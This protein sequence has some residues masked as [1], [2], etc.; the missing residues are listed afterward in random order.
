MNN[1]VMTKAE[2]DA[3]Y[4]SPTW[5]KFRKQYITAH[6]DERECVLCLHPV[7]G[8]NLILDH[9]V[10]IRQGGAKTDENNIQVLCL[11]CNSRKRSN[12]YVRANFVDEEMVKL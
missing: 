5:K 8:R 4:T 9:I 6:P 12:I 1:E 10:G 11:S 3:F 7:E 2:A